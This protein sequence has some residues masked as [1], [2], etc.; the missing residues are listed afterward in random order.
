MWAKAVKWE[1][2]ES[3]IEVRKSLAIWEEAKYSK[4]RFVDA[5]G[6]EMEMKQQK[7]L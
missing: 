4:R 2:A 1:Q 5:G 6:L 3:T 7:T